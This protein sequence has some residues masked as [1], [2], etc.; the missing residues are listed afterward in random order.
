MGFYIIGI[1]KRNKNKK[2]NE[3]IQPD[4]VTT[5][6]VD[7]YDYYD[8]YNF[9]P[10]RLFRNF[11]DEYRERD[12]RPVIIQDTKPIYINVPSIPSTTQPAQQNNL[13][14]FNYPPKRT[15]PPSISPPPL[16]AVSPSSLPEPEAVDL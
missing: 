3:M 6:Y 2:S 12:D 5:T 14:L 9:M 4:I 10:K 15:E 7:N 8:Y 13:N 16:S 11:Y 1:D